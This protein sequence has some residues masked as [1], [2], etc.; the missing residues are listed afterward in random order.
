GVVGVGVVRGGQR[1]GAY[2]DGLLHRQLARSGLGPTDRAFATELVYGTL[3]WRGRIDY[4]LGRCLDRPLER[5]EGI[6]ATALRL[7]AYQ[8]L[9]NDRVPDSAAV[10]EAVRCAPGAGAEGVTGL[11]HAALRR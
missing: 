3:R 4:L 11:V 9:F 6:A 8:I 2:G 1:A 5:V 7:G 10:D